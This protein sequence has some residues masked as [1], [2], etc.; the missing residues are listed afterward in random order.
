MS[1]ERSSGDLGKKL[2]EARER[3]G[4]SLRQI[5]N[6]TKIAVSVLEALERNDIS[7]LPGG[8]FGRAFVRSFATEVGL[9]PEVTIQE[10]MAQFPQDS[11]TV[12][13]PTTDQIDDKEAIESDRRMASTF[14][15]LIAL[16][17]PIA[18]V[19]VYF[20][21]GGRFGR[22]AA[23]DQ[24]APALAPQTAPADAPEAQASAPAVANAGQAT[25]GDTAAAA[26]DPARESFTVSVVVTRLCRVSAIVDGRKQ[27]ERFLQA[28]D[29]RQLEVHRELVLSVGDAGAVQM[30]INGVEANSLGKDGELVT[31]RLNPA[32]FRTYLPP[33]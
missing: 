3:R 14:L 31:A 20:T 27:I 2:R 29:R 17:I 18:V 25:G 15:R 28:G 30:S 10:F 23:V 4:V 6:S 16:S 8:I 12:G 9:D 1:V 5:A 24:P 33:R 21:M 13:H 19:V 11:V 26:D 7:R 22:S 32:N